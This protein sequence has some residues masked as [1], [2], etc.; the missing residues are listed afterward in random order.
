MKKIDKRSAGKFNSGIPAIVLIEL[1]FT[2]LAISFFCLHFL[3]LE[4]NDENECK[5]KI[6][7]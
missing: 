2:F 4:S 5:K 7:I 1:L 6:S 3:F